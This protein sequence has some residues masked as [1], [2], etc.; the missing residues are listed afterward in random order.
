M[1][2]DEEEEKPEGNASQQLICMDG[3]KVRIAMA[4]SFV[5]KLLRMM[6]YFVL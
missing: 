4:R 1:K 3:E 2:N 5:S 6:Q